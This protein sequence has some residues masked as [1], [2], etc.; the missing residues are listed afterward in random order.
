MSDKI[1]FK[2]IL[3]ADNTSGLDVMNGHE[4]LSTDQRQLGPSCILILI[5]AGKV[6]MNL[7]IFGARHRNVSASFLGY[8]CISL[9]AVDFGLLFVVAFIHYFQD[10]SVLGFRI[11]NYHICL[12]TQIISHTYGIL[13]FP[14]FLVSGLDYYL[15]IVKSI[16]ISRIY[17]GLLYSIYVLLLW[18]TAFVYVLRSPIDSPTV[19]SYETAYLCTFYISRQSF[20]LSVALVL[21]I[22]MVFA[23]CCCE[24]LAF[25]KSLKVISSA[26]NIIVLFSFPSGDQWPI[27][28]RKPFL[29]SL[30]FSFLGTW[31]PFVVL[32]IIIFILC[33]HIPAYM[34]MNVPWLYFVNSFLIAV[35][36]GLKYPDLPETEN[37]FS[38][39]PFVGWKYCALPFM[40]AEQKK[41]I[42]LLNE[43][44][45]AVMIV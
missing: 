2:S 28:G 1:L 12:F 26:N 24:M 34:D 25:I 32:Q 39:D 16:K 42:L 7:L 14:V 43:L 5:I 4:V 29:A 23:E 21:T 6:I 40:V 36:L 41:D 44:P 17:P 15:T 20:Y 38:T 35:S 37:I 11:T 3:T 22:F 8:F 10:F 31:S 19:D 27:Q 30:L 45:S 33:A 13:H 9:A 18:I